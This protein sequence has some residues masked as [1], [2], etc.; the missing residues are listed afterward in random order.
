MAQS[1]FTTYTNRT[2]GRTTVM[3]GVKLCGYVDRCPDENRA[4]GF[5]Y[6]VS[7]AKNGDVIPSYCISDKF[8]DNIAHVQ[9]EWEEGR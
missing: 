1:P 4:R 7:V 2:T 8:A 9:R 6:T 3:H 5:Y